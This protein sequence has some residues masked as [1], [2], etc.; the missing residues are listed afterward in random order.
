[1][2][3][4]GLRAYAESWLPAGPDA[5]HPDERDRAELRALLDA[6]KGDTGAGDGRAAADEAERELRDRFAG[7]LGFGTAGLRGKTGPGPTRMTRPVVGATTA[8][9]AAWL[10]GGAAARTHDAGPGHC[11]TPAVV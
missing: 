7:R 6:A 4:S 2:I 10:A 3:D 1:M 8:A 9:V 11:G 5:R